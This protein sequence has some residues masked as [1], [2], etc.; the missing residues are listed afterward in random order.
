MMLF[1]LAF[2]NIKKSVSDYAIYFFTLVLGVAIFSVYRDRL[3]RKGVI[4][5]RQYGKI[6]MALPRFEE[7][8]KNRL[9]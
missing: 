6:A 9:Y 5:T 1:K 3:K 7:Y 2:K 8:V 4:D